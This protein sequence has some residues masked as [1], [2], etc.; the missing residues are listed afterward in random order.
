M[1]TL[2]LFLLADSPFVHREA[3]FEFTA[4]APMSRVAP[5][6]GAD[7]ERVWSPDWNPRFLHPTPAS[8]Q[9]GMVF[10]VDHQHLSSIWVNTQL[11]VKN[12]VIQYVY[13]IPGVLATVITLKLT[14]RGETT[15]VRVEY[16]RTALSAEANAH[17]EQLWAQDRKAGPE[18]EQ[19]INAYL[20]K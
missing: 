13:V 14:P 5:L 6:F 9:R 20:A 7:K 19:K 11:D 12:G 17:V 8:D 16:D 1:I 18:W 4:R 2:L 3:T 10:T 15:H